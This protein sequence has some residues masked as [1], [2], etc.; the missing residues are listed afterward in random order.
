VEVRLRRR[1]ESRYLTVKRGSGSERTEVEVEASAEQFD[2]L[3]P[4]TAGR[5][6]R[7]VR[8]HVPT[9]AGKIEVDV[10]R[11]PLEGLIT[12][13][14]EFSPG[15]RPGSFEPPD[16]IGEELTGHPGYANRSLAARGIPSDAPIAL[17]DQ[18]PGRERAL[19]AMLEQ[20]EAGVAAVAEAKLSLRASLHAPGTRVGA[21]LE[22]WAQR[23]DAIRK[24]ELSQCCV[25]YGAAAI[26]AAKALVDSGRLLAQVGPARDS[27]AQLVAEQ[28]LDRDWMRSGAPT[29]RWRDC[30]AANQGEI[31][32]GTG[33]DPGLFDRLITAAGL[34]AD[35]CD[36]LETPD[37]GSRDA[38]GRVDVRPGHEG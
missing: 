26:A 28:G 24:A 21:A 7:K 8:H 11:G 18:Q 36:W 30:F 38:S 34:A 16:W 2:A 13:E 14:I 29:S 12:A 27:I 33:A 10:Y 35:L 37:A 5:R 25:E 20:R 19:A 15:Q 31:T 32:D 22:E 6:L 4:L 1:A 3:W 17:V 9:E 23:P